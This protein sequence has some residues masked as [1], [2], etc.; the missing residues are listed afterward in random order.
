M[1]ITITANESN[2]RLDRFLRKYC[3]KQLPHITLKDIYQMIRT[4]K[5][6]VNQRKSKED[7]RL[8]TG[9][10]ITFLD[11]QDLTTSISPSPQKSPH[12]PKNLLIPSKISQ[13]PVILY[14][15]QHRLAFDK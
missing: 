10:T 4:G 15:D 13:S 11:T 8:Q 9:D 5:V 14:Q 7:T 3:K 1:H 2:Q 6:K 12:P